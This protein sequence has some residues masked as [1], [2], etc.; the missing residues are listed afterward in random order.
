MKGVILTLNP[1]AAVVDVT[2]SVAP[3]DVRAGAFALDQVCHVFPEGTIHVGVV[4]PGVGT[5][6][7][8]VCVVIGGHFFLAPDNGLLS[9]VCRREPPA[10]VVRLACRDYWRRE[11]SRQLRAGVG[12]EVVV[13][14]TA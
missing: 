2:H 10:S 6:R 14:W 12:D 1:T 3:Q 8:L 11:V 13:S 9:L 5:E 7:A 4:D